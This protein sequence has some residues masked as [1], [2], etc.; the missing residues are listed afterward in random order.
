[1][2]QHLVANEINRSIMAY[3]RPSTDGAV[4]VPALTDTLIWIFRDIYVEIRPLI[5]ISRYLFGNT[6][7]NNST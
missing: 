1:M 7:Y 2:S 3:W 6:V 4:S 5:Q